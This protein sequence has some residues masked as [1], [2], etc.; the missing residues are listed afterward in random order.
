MLPASRV[1]PPPEG[2]HIG[3]RK[4]CAPGNTIFNQPYR[5]RVSNDRLNREN[6]QLAASLEGEPGSTPAG[7]TLPHS[8][9]KATFQR[10]RA[11]DTVV[12]AEKVRAKLRHAVVYPNVT[13]RTKEKIAQSKWAHAGSLAIVD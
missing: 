2:H 7:K 5:R 11:R 12:A 9:S 6:S 1:S 3:A 4:G 13:G 8:Y 10:E